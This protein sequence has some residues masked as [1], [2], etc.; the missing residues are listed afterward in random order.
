MYLANYTRPNIAFVINL[1]ARYSSNPIKRHCN[2]VKY[3]LN[4]LYETIKM[5]LFYS[6][7]NSQLI[8]YVYACYL[9]DPYKK[10]IT[11][12][13]SIYLWRY[14]N[15]LEICQTN[16]N[17]FFIKSVINYYNPESKSRMYMVKV[18]YPAHKNKIWIVNHWW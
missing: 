18:N 1:L 10:D 16:I 4:Y 15:F 7:L 11:N 8:G 9:F 17:G 12:K 2:V 13:L 5:R 3:I 6:G 14:Y